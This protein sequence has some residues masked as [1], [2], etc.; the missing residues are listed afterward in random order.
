MDDISTHILELCSNAKNGEVVPHGIPREEMR[1]RILQF[2]SKMMAA[3]EAGEVDK[4]DINETFPLR[5]F[6]APNTYAREMTLPA[7]NWII[8]KIHKHAHLNI[9]TKGRVAV[10]TEDGVMHVSG[11]HTFVS[12]PGTKRLVMILEET[13]WTTVHVTDKTDLAEIEDEVIAKSYDDLLTL[14]NST[15]KELS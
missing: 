14:E 7:G 12:L 10:I 3:Q 11:H 2:Q 5:H 13:V 9:I 6:F 8:G 15:V 4:C 1:E